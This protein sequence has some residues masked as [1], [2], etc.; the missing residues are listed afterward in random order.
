MNKQQIEITID[1]ERGRLDKVLSNLIAEVSRNQ[2]QQ[3]IAEGAV[4]VNGEKQP[5]KY[6]VASG[7][8][9]QVTIPEPEEIE[10]KPQNIP[11]EIVYEDEDIA[12]VNKPQGM[13]VHPALGHPD[14]TLVNALLYHLDNLSG[15]N[16]KIRPGIVHRIDKDTSGLLMVAKNDQAHHHLSA[17]LKEK[18]S[19]REYIALVHGRIPHEKATIDAPIG[20]DPHDRKKYAVVDDGKEAITHFNVLQRFKADYTLIACQLETGRTHQIRV[21]LKYINFPMAGDPEYGPSKT[22]AGNGQFLHAA[23]LGFIHPRTEE[24]MEFNCPLPD[25]F[26]QTIAELEKS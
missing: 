10:A 6:K 15:I 23:T 4:L 20:R 26:T 7:D 3:L 13:V 18:T 22:L 8:R 1:Q 17:Q 14:G 16:G 21:H 12:V 5:N 19:K 2:I 24:Y 9:V 11:L 25:I